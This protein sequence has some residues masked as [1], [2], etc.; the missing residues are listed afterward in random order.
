MSISETGDF[1]FDFELYFDAE[2]SITYNDQQLDLN[3]QL[4]A[5]VMIVSNPS[6]LTLMIERCWATP[7]SNR[8][9]LTSY[10]LI[11]QRCVL[12]IHVDVFNKDFALVCFLIT[13]D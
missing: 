13:I 5:R 12:L 6:Y 1:D 10:D 4:Y 3:V 11:Y 8:N 2:R 9:D 7:T